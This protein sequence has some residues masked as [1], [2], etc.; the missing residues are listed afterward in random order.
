MRRAARTFVLV[1]A[2]LCGSAVLAVPAPAAPAL[3]GPDRVETQPLTGD[4]GLGDD[5]EAT[6][7][8]LHYPSPFSTMAHPEACDWI[9]FIRYRA[10]HGPADSADADA[11]FSVQPGTYSGAA[12]MNIQAPQVIRKAAEKGKF[13]E[14]IS[15]ERRA[16]CAEDRTGWDAAQRAGDY[17]VAADYYFRG[18][19]VEGRTYRYQGSQDLA[20]LGEYGLALTLDDWRVVIEHLLPDPAQRTKSFCGGH[21]LGAFLTGPMMAWN[22]AGDPGVSDASGFNL[23]GGGIVPEDGF[24]MTDPAGLSG[25]GLIDQFASAAGGLL[26][27]AVNLLLQNGLGTAQWPVLSAS[28]IMNAYQ[29]AGMAADQDP[30]GDSE[31]AALV[32]ADLRAE[33]WMRLMYGKDYLDLFTGANLPRD[34]KLTNTSALGMLFDQNSAEYVMQ[35]GLGFYDC[36]TTGKTYPVPNGLASV[37]ILG[38]TLFIIPLRVGY[39][40][41]YVPTDHNTRCGWRNYDQVWPSSIDGPD[42]GRGT[43]TD[44]DHEV[45][46]IRQFAHAMNPGWQPVDFFEQYTPLRLITDMIFAMGLGR[47]GDLS[48]M[49]YRTGGILNFLLHGDRW[50]S[51]PAGRRNLTLLAGDS[52]LQNA[53]YAG[54]LPY[55]AK[56]IAGY[57]HYDIVTAA[58]TQNSGVPEL[59]STYIANFLIAPA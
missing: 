40:Q 54:L 30:N 6:V 12:S 16:N 1:L 42:L 5:I 37:P 28:E 31:L 48:N 44:S 49:Q 22:F 55:N 33:P 26:K 27:N 51:T 3:G 13:V 47:D 52:P 2:V 45:T 57:R 20:F 4:P 10:K 11:V 38:P 46:D 41:N 29:L 17:R 19:Q 34:Y 43:P 7:V 25:T 39:G 35:A 21:S 56:L 8:R 24:A 14:Y 15:L 9:S 59:A 58:E 50:Q 23:C 18:G 32:P 36:A 53:G